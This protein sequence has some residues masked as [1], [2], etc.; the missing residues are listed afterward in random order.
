MERHAERM[1]DTIRDR[2]MEEVRAGVTADTPGSYFAVWRAAL[3][4]S[5][6]IVREIAAINAHLGG[7]HQR[8]VGW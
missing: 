7:W 1:R 2:A 4:H 5:Q 3:E 8:T 6:Q